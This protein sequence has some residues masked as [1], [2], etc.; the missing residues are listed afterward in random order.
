MEMQSHTD[1]NSQYHVQAILLVPVGNLVSIAFGAPHY[2]SY[3][4]NFTVLLELLEVCM[5][6]ILERM[7]ALNAK[8]FHLK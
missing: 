8:I 4:V 7:E 3:P 2:T 6:Y 5:F 1:T